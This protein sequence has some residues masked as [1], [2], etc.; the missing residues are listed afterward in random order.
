MKAQRTAGL[1]GRS[2]RSNALDD[3]LWV[4]RSGG[5][6]AIAGAILGLVGNLLHPATSGPGDPAATA[7]VVAESDIWIPL[8][9]ALLVSFILMLGGLVAIHDSITGGLPGA[10]AR[11]GLMAAIVG[12]TGGVVL[13]SLDGFAAKHLAESWLSA[14]AGVRPTAL[15]AFRAEDSIN[16]ALLSPLN[17][18]FAGFTF[19]LYGLAAALSQVYPRWLGWIAV[20]GGAGGAASGVIQAYIGEPSAITTALGIAAPTIITLWLLIMGIL[21]VR[22]GQDVQIDNSPTATEQRGK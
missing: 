14:P 12:T 19:V 11:F 18:V 1:E 10:L 21:L 20:V 16:F 17:L 22:R 4:L 15:A 8:H 3:Q 2:M 5:G 13:L 9:I 7:R 6:S